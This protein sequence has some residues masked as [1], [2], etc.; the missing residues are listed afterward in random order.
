M[1]DH[2]ADQ[3]PERCPGL[4]GMDDARATSWRSRTR[5]TATTRNHRC[6]RAPGHVGP[7]EFI[8]PCIRVDDQAFSSRVAQPSMFSEA[9]A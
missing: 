7:C 2:V 4:C 3:M 9:S 1:V 8:R 6:L 5:P